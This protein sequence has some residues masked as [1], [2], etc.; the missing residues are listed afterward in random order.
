MDKNKLYTLEKINSDELYGDTIERY[1]EKNHINNVYKLSSNENPYGCSKKVL[2]VLTNEHILSIYPD[3]HCSELRFELEKFYGI[4]NTKFLFGNGSLELIDLICKTF[5]NENNN[6][7]TCTPTFEVY[8]SLVEKYNSKI[9]K[10]PLKDFKFD[11]DNIIDNIKHNTKVIFITNP[12]NPTGTLLSLNE[13]T[14]FLNKVR[15]DII[16]VIDEAYIEVIY[17]NRPDTIS[18]LDKYENVILLRTFSKA[19]GL[20]GLRIGY[21]MTHEKNVSKLEKNRLPFNM[22]SIIQQFAIEAIKDQDFVSEF[23]EKNNEV[24]NYIYDFLDK[25]NVSY[26]KSV[27]NF[28]MIKSNKLNELNKKGFL[29]KGKYELMEDYIRVSIGT[30]NEMKLFCSVFESML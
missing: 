14:S 17:E 26:I 15:K 21:L 22:S 12:N 27:G 13:I 29:V 2:D 11:L 23:R 1:K 7:I 3:D 5:L 9:N 16:V 30:M 25:H 8:Y 6:A 20:A 4:K 19:Y 28:I 18:L 10:L 24:K